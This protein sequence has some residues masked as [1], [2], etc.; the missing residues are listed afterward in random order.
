MELQL[1]KFNVEVIT[2]HYL[3]QAEFE[4]RGDVT[5]F[6]NDDRNFFYHFEAANVRPLLPHYQV[7]GLK[8]PHFVLHRKKIVYLALTSAEDAADMQLLVTKRP[9]ILYT[10][11]LAIQGNFHVNADAR[12]HDLIDGSKEY[13]AVT[14]AKVFPLRKL[15]NAPARDVPFLALNT[16][17]ITAYHVQAAAS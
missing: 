10:D 11:H 12:D 2:S 16:H 9:V 15:A 5:I 4:P 3:V 17:L 1:K 13:V 8:Q 6:L 14:D 7:P